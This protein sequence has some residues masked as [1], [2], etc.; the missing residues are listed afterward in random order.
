YAGVACSDWSWSSAFLDVDLDGHQD[1]LVGTGHYYD[2]QDQDATERAD[3]LSPTEKNDVRKTLSLY[4]PLL[5]PNYAFHNR[6]NLTYE[7][8]GKQW[9]FDSLQVSHSIALAD[10]DNDGDLDVVVNCLRSPA[11]VYRNNCSAPRVAVRLKGLPP[12]TRGIG[13]RITLLG[14]AVPVQ[15][16]EMTCGGRFLAGD[17]P[18]RTFAAGQGD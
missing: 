17:A 9:G 4:P 6:G 8:V 18:Q 12:N 2:T 1:I 11:L 14:G 5:T 13:A 3:K 16:Q 10:L 7:E 15:S